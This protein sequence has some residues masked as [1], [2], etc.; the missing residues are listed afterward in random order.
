[1]ALL[2]LLTNA[3]YLGHSTYKDAVV[4]PN[5]HQPIVDNNLFFEVFNSISNVELNGDPNPNYHPV[6][7]NMR[8]TL[9]EDRTEERPLC[10][11]LIF[12]LWNGKSIPVNTNWTKGSKWYAYGVR[13]NDPGETFLWSRRSRTVDEAVVAMFRAKLSA[14]F[15]VKAWAATEAAFSKN[16]EKEQ[17]VKRT[18][19]R[20]LEDLMQRQVENLAHVST[21]EMIEQS[22]KLYKG[23]QAER[24]RLL[25]D[26]QQVD[27]EIQKHQALLALKDTFGTI[28]EDWDYAT[29]EERISILQS[30]VELIEANP[31]DGTGLELVI[32]WRDNSSDKTVIKIGHGKRIFW[33]DSEVDQLN[34]LIVTDASQ[35]EICAAFPTRTW[36]AIWYKIRSSNPG[37]EIPSSA[38]PIHYDETYDDF[39]NRTGGKV[40]GFK[41]KAG[42]VWS[43]QE[44]AVLVKLVQ[45]EATQLEIARAFPHRPWQGIRVRITRLLGKNVKIPDAVHLG[46][47]ENYAEYNIRVNGN[48]DCDTNDPSCATEQPL[49][50]VRNPRTTASFH[51]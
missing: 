35:L 30:F 15:D 47:S 49:I 8:P 29:R 44:D 36:Q 32:R 24:T 41:A 37:W 43:Q 33:L 2:D 14:T 40:D 31:I 38:R 13:G 9:E 7:V 23:Y 11:G 17:K 39:L 12:T 27:D 26:L 28:A 21:I 19:V 45:S 18:E 10:S 51:H 1:M 42:T 48:G 5:N 3:A 16:Y 34:N 50:S 46:V 22:E 25:N 6:R 20:M 4:V